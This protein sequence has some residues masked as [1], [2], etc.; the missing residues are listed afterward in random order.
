MFLTDAFPHIKVFQDQ[1]VQVYKRR[2][3]VRTLLGRRAYCDNP[4]FAYRAVSR[5][6]Q[7]VGGEHLKICLLRACQYEDTYPNDLQ[8]LLTIHDSLL[9][10]RNPNHD[11]K[12]LIHSV[13]DVAQ[14]LGLIVP[15]PFDVGSGPDWA[16]ASYGDKLDKYED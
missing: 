14:E 4:Q 3:Y 12:E 6:I 2:G 1:A 11:P 16:R 8:V 9:W 13:E 5:I 15:I 7:N 10:Q